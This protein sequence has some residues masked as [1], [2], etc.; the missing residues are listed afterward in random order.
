MQSGGALPMFPG[1]RMQRGY[2]RLLRGNGLGGVLRRLFRSA[3]PFLIR[4]GK[5]IGRQALKQA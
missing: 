3:M 1:A 5:E 2:G 4:N